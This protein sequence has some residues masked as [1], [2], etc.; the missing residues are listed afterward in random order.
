VAKPGKH[1]PRRT[2]I[3]CREV[4]AKRTLTRIVRTAEGV[5]VDPHGKLNGRGAY[6]HENRSCWEKGLDGRLAHAL[7]TKLSA[8]EIAHLTAYIEEQTQSLSAHGEDL[9]KN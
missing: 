4:D 9:S 5:V 8:E 1:K 7:K 2:C 6:L 3:G